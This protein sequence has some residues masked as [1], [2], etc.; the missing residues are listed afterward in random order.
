MVEGISLIQAAR[1]T[2]LTE[3]FSLMQDSAQDFT[4]FINGSELPSKGGHYYFC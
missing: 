3:C 1:K 4:T 2:V